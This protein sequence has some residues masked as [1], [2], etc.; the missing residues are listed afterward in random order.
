M[1]K[2]TFSS[3]FRKIDVDQYSEDNYKEEETDPSGP[4]G[5]DENEVISLLNK[6]P[7]NCF[8]L[9]FKVTSL[10]LIYRTLCRRLEGCV[11]KCPA[12][13]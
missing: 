5:P 9:L 12:W 11:V 3:A 10:I 8:K 6:Y 13:V 4:T 7:F 2:N 1:A